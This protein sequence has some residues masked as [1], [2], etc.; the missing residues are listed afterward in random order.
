MRIWGYQR[1]DDCMLTVAIVVAA[2]AEHA[3]VLLPPIGGVCGSS[4]PLPAA[5]IDL[6]E[7]F[8]P[9]RLILWLSEEVG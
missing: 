3:L 5:F 2:S 6:G 9:A 8:G 7:A 1:K 4:R